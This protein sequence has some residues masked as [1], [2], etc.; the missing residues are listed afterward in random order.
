MQHSAV[1]RLYSDLPVA[2]FDSLYPRLLIYVDRYTQ[3][4]P[5]ASSHLQGQG[6]NGNQK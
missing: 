3:K 6:C 5:I 1:F 4:T 2:V